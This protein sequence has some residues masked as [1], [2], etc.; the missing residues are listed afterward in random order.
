MHK[1]HDATVRYLDKR[2]CLQFPETSPCLPGQQENCKTTQNNCGTSRIFFT[3]PLSQVTAC[4]STRWNNYRSC[5]FGY[6]AILCYFF[7]SRLKNC[8][9]CLYSIVAS[10]S[11]FAWCCF[12][13][14]NLFRTLWR[15]WSSEWDMLPPCGMRVVLQQ[16]LILSVSF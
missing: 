6:C 12:A 7:P 14:S 2:F 10:I 13:C 4:P 9:G 8:S 1:Y 15:T 5:H 11:F 16:D 3:K